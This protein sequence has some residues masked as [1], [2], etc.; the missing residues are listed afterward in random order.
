MALKPSHYG[1]FQ[2]YEAVE[3]LLEAGGDPLLKDKQGLNAFDYASE[4]QLLYKLIQKHCPKGKPNKSKT[5]TEK[6]APPLE[7]L[8][9]GKSSELPPIHFVYEADAEKYIA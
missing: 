2:N 6:E 4:S 1:I 8:A 3:I 5:P 7:V 9:S